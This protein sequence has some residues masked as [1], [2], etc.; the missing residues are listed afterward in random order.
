MFE[1]A[2]LS[3]Q[4]LDENGNFNEVNQTWLDTMGYTRDEVLGKNFSDFLVPDWKD[5]FKENFPRFK[6]V[7]E[8]LGVEFEMVKKDGDVILVSFHGKI[9]KNEMGKFKQT[10]CIFQDIT[11]V[12][13]AEES[14][15]R[16]KERL[17]S[18]WNITKI[19]DSD[20]K[21]I[22]DHVLEEVQKMTQSQYAFY[23]FLD[24]NEN[25][26]ILHAWSHETM[27]DCKTNE[28]TIHFA[29]DKAGIWAEAVKEKNI[30]TIND[31]KLDHPGK[32]GVPDGHVQL[33]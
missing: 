10:H 11:G 19:A 15:N 14:S 20:I 24:K 17:E 30:L 26:M 18:L 27:D 23:G 32:K 3:Y 7:G 29:I 4:S 6:A 16:L 33:T 31:F 28:K 9:A 5:H 13:Q 21:T 8:I 22:S 12:R 2:P 25:E 1:K